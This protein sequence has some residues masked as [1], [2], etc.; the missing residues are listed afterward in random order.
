MGSIGHA[1][2]VI[3][4]AAAAHDSYSRRQ[5]RGNFAGHYKSNRGASSR[6]STEA[7]IAN[8][9][10]AFCNRVSRRRSAKGYA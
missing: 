6:N 4:M 2:F 8:R 9:H 1:G 7:G 5:D 3:A 10:R